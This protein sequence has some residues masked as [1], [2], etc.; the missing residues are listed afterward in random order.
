MS[1]LQTKQAIQIA[2]SSFESEPLAKA[3]ILLFETLGYK[4]QKRLQLK[5]N[6]PESFITTFATHRPF[7][8]EAAL[9]SDWQ[10]VDFLFQLTDEEIQGAALDSQPVLFESRGKY[11]G[12]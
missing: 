8:Q 12:A 1:D 4:S 11:D 3:A 9:V 2:L 6:S 10:S 7:N 5:P